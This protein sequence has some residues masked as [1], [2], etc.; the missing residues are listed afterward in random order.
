MRNKHPGVCYRCGQHCA[1]GD[2]HFE[3]HKGGWRVQHAKC[4][5]IAKKQKQAEYELSI[6]Q[7]NPTLGE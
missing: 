1:A 6:S 5:I 7:P 4:A 2:G 3:R